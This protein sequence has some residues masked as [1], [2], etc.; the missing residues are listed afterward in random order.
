MNFKA[1]SGEEGFSTALAKARQWCA[2]EE[3]CAWDIKLKL[4]K[5]GCSLNDISR[6]IDQI[7]NEGFINEQRY[8]DSYVSGKFRISKWGKVKIISGM[9]M[10]K[11][12]EIIITHSIDTIDQETYRNSLVTLLK[13]KQQELRSETPEHKRQKLVR[14][15]LQKGYESELIYT[16][17]GT[18]E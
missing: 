5:L 3:R 14:F 8:A 13:K 17:L 7:T 12:P 10:K 16:L 4:I 9:R 18:N 11:I 1:N 2:I 6:I 15:A